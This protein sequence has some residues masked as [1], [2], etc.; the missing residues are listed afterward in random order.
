MNKPKILTVLLHTGIGRGTA[1]S[2]AEGGCHRLFLAD[3]DQQGLE[4]TKRQLLEAHPTIR[5]KILRLDISDEADVQRMVDQ[6]V[7]TFGRLDYAL[8][9]AGV[10]PNRTP[11]AMV[12]VQVY[13]KVVNVNE[14]GV[15]Q[16]NRTRLAHPSSTEF[17]RRRVL[18]VADLA[19]PSGGDSPDDEAAT[20]ARSRHDAREHRHHL[21]AR[22]N[23]RLER[24][25]DVLRLKARYRWFCQS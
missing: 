7:L 24:H 3:I 23:Q 21:V 22:W 10:V 5:A 25:V 20:V 2:L 19:L 13:D 12:D 1:I 11:I 15:S 18:T 6:C 14:Y 17:H 9:I 8:N 4:E 16:T